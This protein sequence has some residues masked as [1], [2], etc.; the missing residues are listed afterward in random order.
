MRLTRRQVGIGQAEG[1]QECLREHMQEGLETG[2]DGDEG[3][4]VHAPLIWLVPAELAASALPL[5]ASLTLV[6]C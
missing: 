6:G 3:W 1:M 5:G 4:R 2:H